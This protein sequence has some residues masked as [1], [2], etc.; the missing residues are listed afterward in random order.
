[1]RKVLETPKDKRLKPAAAT[2]V[3]AFV[4]VMVTG[5]ANGHLW[6]EIANKEGGASPRLILAK[7]NPGGWQRKMHFAT[8]RPQHSQVE[9][10]RGTKDKDSHHEHS[11]ILYKNFSHPWQQKAF[12]CLVFPSF[13][14][15][16]FW[17]NFLFSHPTRC[18]PVSFLHCIHLS[19]AL[20]GSEFAP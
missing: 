9:Y 19:Y 20:Q 2:W 3:K 15:N 18:L 4:R 13:L 14:L 10:R 7:P 17:I 5:R 12:F 16:P 6:Q 8:F 11:C 1:M